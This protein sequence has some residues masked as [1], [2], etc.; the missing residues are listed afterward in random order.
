MQAIDSVERI[1]AIGDSIV[2]GRID[3]RG[4]G[5][6]SRL[7]SRFVGANPGRRLLY[8]LGIAGET[9]EGL[10][11]RLWS[12]CTLR[13]PDLILIG[14]G[15]NDSR[16]EGGPE[17]P[18]RTEETAFRANLIKS[19]EISRALARVVFVTMIP[20][21]E[22]RTRPLRENIYYSF[23]TQERYATVTQEVLLSEG[24]EFVDVY[25]S[26]M[27]LSKEARSSLLE[28]GLHPN[29]DGHRRICRQV[30]SQLL[31]RGLI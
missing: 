19:I 11:D 9:S 6:V 12:E 28:D 21:D 23:S 30:T 16:S 13:K 26:W 15:V 8:N 5:W 10:L 3:S 25:R 2:A 18:P 14:I 4:G 24:V 31:R 7:Q 22:Q 20:I 27:A 17:V 29:A 1:V